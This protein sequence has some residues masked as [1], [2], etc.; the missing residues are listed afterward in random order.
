MRKL[1]SI[2][3]VTNIRPI[4]DRDLIEQVN[5]NGWNIIVKKGEFNEGDKCVYIEIDSKLPP[6]KEFEFLEKKKYVIKTMKMAGV[7]SEGIVFPLSILPLWFRFMAVGTNVTWALGITQYNKEADV[8]MSIGKR[9]FKLLMRYSWFR[10]M[11]KARLVKSSAQTSFPRWITKTDEERIQNKP[12]VLSEANIW[13]A[14]EKLDGSS[15][16]YGIRK[17]KDGFEYVVCSRNLQLFGTDNIWH[18][19]SERYNMQAV[20]EKLI[21]AEGATTSIVLQGEIIGPG[22]Q[23]NKYRLSDIEFYVFNLKVDGVNKSY[24]SEA[25]AEHHSL[26]T[27]PVIATLCLTFM[28]VDDVLAYATFKSNINKDVLAEG[29]VFRRY[30]LNA[31]V[32]DSFKAVSPDFLIKNKE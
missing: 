1:A 27:V 5:V 2:Q 11:I 17:T 14:T 24:V 32:V 26:K 19:I 4:P 29:I 12:W 22:I 20:L 9:I 8:K 7:R 13:T 31:D 25:L 6:R 21:E 18:R 30:D 3:T 28:S 10:K 23:G 15:A 16:T